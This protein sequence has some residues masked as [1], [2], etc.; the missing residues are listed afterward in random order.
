MNTPLST[1]PPAP[2][3]LH[4]ATVLPDWID[5]NGHMRD[6]YYAVAFSDA[7]DAVLDYLDLGAGYRSRTGCALYT[8][9]LH[10][11]FERELKAGA[12]LEFA[13]LVLGVDAKRLH[14]FHCLYHA[15]ESYLAATNEVLLLHVDSQPR[16]GPMPAELL[17]RAE[18]VAAAHRLVPRPPE[19]G[20][21]I[22]QLVKPDSNL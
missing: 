12:G 21:R 1:D 14:L 2:L 5:Y 22:A 4:T 7:T 3:W 10:F 6:G 20:G 8:V 16:V 13:S 19:V 17:A 9:E 11:N 15:E 18:A